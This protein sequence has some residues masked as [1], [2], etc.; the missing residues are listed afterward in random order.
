MDDGL[1]PDDRIGEGGN[2]EVIEGGRLLYAYTERDG[3]IVYSAM[4]RVSRG[5]RFE[6]IA[7]DL[8]MRIGDRLTNPAHR[9][10]IDIDHKRIRYSSSGGARRLAAAAAGYD[11]REMR[12][13]I[14]NVFLNP[15]PDR[16]DHFYHELQRYIVSD[17]GQNI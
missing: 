7:L 17:I 1:Y 9:V 3:S 15:K 5:D 4:E 8:C 13:R 2:L 14:L 11:A 16:K 10:I 6:D 12:G